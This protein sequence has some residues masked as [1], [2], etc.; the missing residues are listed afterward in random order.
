MRSNTRCASRRRSG[1]PTRTL[2]ATVNPA[3]HDV[4][5]HRDVVQRGLAADPA[6]RGREEVP[7]EPLASNGRLERDRHDVVPLLLVV[8]VV[9]VGDAPDV[10]GPRPDPSVN[11]NPAASS[12]SPPGVRIVTATALARPGRGPATR[13]SRGSSVASASGRSDR[14]RRRAPS[15]TRT[16]VTLRRT[17]SGGGH[18]SSMARRTARGLTCSHTVGRPDSRASDRPALVSGDP[19]V[20]KERSHMLSGLEIAQAAQLR[21][22]AEVAADAGIEPE[23]LE[24]VRHDAGPRCRCRSW[25]ASPTARTASSSSR[26]PSRRRRPARARPR[27]R[28]SLTQGLGEIGKDVDARLRE[29]SM[30]PVF[31]IKGGGNGGGY[32]QVVPMEE[33]N[34]HFN[35]DFHADHRGAQPAVG[36]ARRV[37]LPRQPA[38]DRPPDDHLAAHPRRERPRAP[39]HGDRARRQGPRRPPRE[40]SSSSPRRRRSWRSSPSRAICRTF[41]RGSAGSSWRR[42]ATDAR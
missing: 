38:R 10:V 15:T 40:G 23:E 41:A 42:P 17:C 25:T 37:D 6:R 18:A 16:G 36:R 39:Q 12:K 21:P 11:R 35:G 28:V 3:R 22:I 2:A 5:P 9:A 26:R 33:I 13:I 14:G 27:R 1:S 34:L 30:G 7:R 8:E 29:P 24:P 19:A 32:A 20:P 31:G 4:A